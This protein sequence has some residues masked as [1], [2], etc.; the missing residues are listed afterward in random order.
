MLKIINELQAKKARGEKG[1]TLIELLIVVAIIGILA[2]IAIP[3]FAAYRIRGF[4]ASA[5]SDVRNGATAQEALFADTQLYGNVANAALATGACGAGPTLL[6]PGPVTAATPAAAGG[7]IRNVLGTVGMT[8]GN[9]VILGVAGLV[10]AAG[11]PCTSY[12]MVTKQTNGDRCFG[13][14]SDAQAVFA[15]N[16][17]A[18]TALVVGDV[19]AAVINTNQLAGTTGAC[20]TWTVQ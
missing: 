18:G 3:Q 5:N 12:V 7:Q 6:G 11:N 9:A 13:R 16:N 14:D 10:P 20:A 15:A 1:F 8:L 17:A 2:A 19:P 4:N